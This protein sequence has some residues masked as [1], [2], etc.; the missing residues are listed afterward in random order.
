MPSAVRLIRSPSLADAPSA[1]AATA[2]AAARLLF[3][4]E[5]EAVAAVV[6]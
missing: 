6:D 4:A 5:V 1:Y 2:P 3:L